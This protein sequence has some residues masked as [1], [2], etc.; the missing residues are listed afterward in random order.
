MRRS[1]EHP[2][3]A[4]NRRTTTRTARNCSSKESANGEKAI[5]LYVRQIRQIKPLTPQEE[6]E[7]VLQ[8]KKGS[9][10][11]RHRLITA[12]LR[13]VAEISREYENIG[14]PLLDLI[15]EGN[16]GLLKAVDRFDPAKGKPF[17]AYRTWW[18]K[19]SIKCALAKLIRALPKQPHRAARRL[20]D[21]PTRCTFFEEDSFV[22]RGLLA[23]TGRL[24]RVLSYSS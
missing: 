14:L 8:C 9:R 13:R 20:F 12:S 6:L 10:K 23:N 24:E 11:A 5:Q 15:S 4:A 17:A 22:G 7:L 3:P 1:T 16:M 21:W 19:Q 2:Q 18:I